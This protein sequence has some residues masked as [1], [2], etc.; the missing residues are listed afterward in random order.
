MDLLLAH[1][2]G[3]IS[4]ESVILRIAHQACADRIQV[5]IG[6][7]GPQRFRRI[8]HQNTFETLRPQSAEPTCLSII[9]TTEPLLELLHEHRHVPHSAQKRFADMD[10]HS[11]VFFHR[12]SG[13]NHQKPVAPIKIFGSAEQLPIARRHRQRYAHQ[14][15]EMVPHHAVGNHLHPAEPRQP[16]QQRSQPLLAL[17]IQQQ[18]PPHR[19]GNTVIDSPAPPFYPRQP[20]A[21]HLTHTNAHVYKY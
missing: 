9:P 8:L 21:Q 1:Q 2:S 13:Q 18:L 6:G 3:R 4:A 5:D 16:H 7:H 14:H 19:P 10:W 12:I 11:P 17:L 20:H 15:M